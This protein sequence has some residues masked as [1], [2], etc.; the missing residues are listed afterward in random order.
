MRSDP[1]FDRSTRACPILA[2]PIRSESAAHSGVCDFRGYCAG[3]LFCPSLQI[4]ID[5]SSGYRWQ[6]YRF[7]N[8]M[9]RQEH[10]DP[11]F[12][13]TCRDVSLLRATSLVY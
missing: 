13:F 7:R 11:C 12:S 6:P 10:E 3:E 4:G 1:A 9:R 5:H 8:H 2:C